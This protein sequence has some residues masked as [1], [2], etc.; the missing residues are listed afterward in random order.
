M[1]GKGKVRTPL[2]I[3]LGTVVVLALVAGTVLLYTALF[4]NSFKAKYGGDAFAAQGMDL[5]TVGFILLVV[6][7]LLMFTFF[8]D[9]KPRE[10][11]LQPRFLGS[12]PSSA[13]A[14]HTSKAV[15]WIVRGLCVIAVAATVFIC[16]NVCTVFSE[17]GITKRFFK[18][19]DEYGWENARSYTI[20]YAPDEGISFTVKMKDGNDFALTSFDVWTDEFA[21]AY[22]LEKNKSVIDFLLATDAKLEELQVT[23]NVIGLTKMEQDMQTGNPETW[24]KIR[25]LVDYDEKMQ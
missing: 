9:T 23:K 15:V 21:D 17:D 11:K 25:A 10:E 5:L 2:F 6:Y 22:Q 3:L 14:P 4:F 1:A 20:T 18:P 19:T 13:S 16:S 24:E 7:E 8:I 12:R